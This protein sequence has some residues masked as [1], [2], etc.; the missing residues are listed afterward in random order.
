MTIRYNLPS[1]QLLEV[2]HFCWMGSYT[3]SFQDISKPCHPWGKKSWECELL[4]WMSDSAMTCVTHKA[5]AIVG[6]PGWGAI[7][8]VICANL[9]RLAMNCRLSLLTGLSNGMY[10]GPL[11]V[12]C[13]FRN[14]SFLKA[15]WASL[16][17]STRHSVFLTFRLSLSSEFSNHVLPSHGIWVDVIQWPISLQGFSHHPGQSHPSQLHGQY[18]LIS[19]TGH[20]Q[21]V[22]LEGLPELKQLFST[23]QLQALLGGAV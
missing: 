19:M 23:P 3:Q 8:G 17:S 15:V 20:P 13:S 22:S 14:G 2:S 16:S 6:K 10:W 1:P 18:R 4:G 21:P 12:C 7:W 5:P 9:T 11:A